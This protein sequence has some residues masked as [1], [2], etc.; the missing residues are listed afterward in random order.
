M[1]DAPVTLVSAPAPRPELASSEE[2]C[3]DG[4]PTEAS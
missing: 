1:D 3:G 4:L 2:R